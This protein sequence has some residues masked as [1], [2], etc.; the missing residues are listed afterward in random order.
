MKSTSQLSDDSS[1]SLFTPGRIVAG[2]VVAMFIAVGWQW[3]GQR[4]AKKERAA[5]AVAAQRQAAIDTA[6]GQLA[7]DAAFTA[8]YEHY[9][10]G[11]YTQSR[12]ALL[13]LAEQGHGRACLVLGIQHVSGMSGPVDVEK[14]RPWFEKAS[15]YGDSMGWVWLGH[16]AQQM[17]TD[18]L[19]Q[20]AAVNY[21]S[22]A[23][24]AGNASGLYNLAEMVENGRGAAP[25]LPR[26]NS[27]Y[28]LAAK[29]FNAD[30]QA[31]EFAPN[32]R[33]GLGSAAAMQRLRPKISPVDLMRSE[34]LAAQWQVGDP[35]P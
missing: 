6:S 8:A 32:S 15:Q 22:K 11:R 24:R 4:Q 25:D 26:A 14:G 16:L 7:V 2:L 35:L 1:D 10:R 34:Q 13:A 18:A 29:T 27:L 19:A 21:F 31:T 23:A 9:R 3:M 5:Q 20:D 17:G 28:A 12:E 30:S 33:S